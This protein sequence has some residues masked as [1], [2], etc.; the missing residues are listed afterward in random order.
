ME[1]KFVCLSAPSQG[2]GKIRGVGLVYDNEQVVN[3]LEWVPC[4]AFK[5]TDFD[6]GGW[7]GPF[8]LGRE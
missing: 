5:H 3:Y 1:T 2:W 6:Q 4:D 7:R 8:G